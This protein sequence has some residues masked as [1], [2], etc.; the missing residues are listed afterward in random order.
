[1]TLSDYLKLSFFTLC[2]AVFVLVLVAL[3]TNIGV[4]IEFLWEAVCLLFGSPMLTELSG[5]PR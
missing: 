2:V 5:L 4:A 3:G 1:M